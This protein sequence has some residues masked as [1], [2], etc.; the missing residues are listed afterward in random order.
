MKRRE[1]GIR[2]KVIKFLQ[3]LLSAA[4]ERKDSLELQKTKNKNK[5]RF[6]NKEKWAKRKVLAGA[7]LRAT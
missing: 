3:Q 7:E 5:T 4:K 6:F 2:R 1:V